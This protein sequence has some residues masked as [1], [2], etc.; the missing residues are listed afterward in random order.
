MTEPI[1]VS[2][3]VVEDFPVE[4]F[5]L[6]RTKY[7]AL[8]EIILRAEPGKVVEIVLNVTDGDEARKIGTALKSWAASRR[9]NIKYKYRTMKD[10]D[11]WKL[12]LRKNVE[13]EK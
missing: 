6:W 8:H 5:R 13:G 12:Y 11:Q 1:V 10:G 7:H 9:A 4:E 3:R 2:H